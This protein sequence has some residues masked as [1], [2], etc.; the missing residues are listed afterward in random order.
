MKLS[1]PIPSGKNVL[2]MAAALFLVFLAACS[3][4]LIYSGIWQDKPVT[5]DGKATEWK[6]PLDYYD[7]KTKLNF[8]ITNDMSNIYFCIRATEDITQKGII[9]NGLQ[10]W[11]DTAGGKKGQVGMQFPVI[12]RTDKSSGTRHSEPQEPTSDETPVAYSLKSNYAGKNKQMKLTGFNGNINGLAEVPNIYGINACLNWDTNNIM[13][14]EA[15]IP[16]NSFYKSRLSL[17]DSSKVIG[18]SFVVTVST[19]GYG[20]GGGG[21]G[22][23]GGGGGGMG[24]GM[25][26]G[27]GGGGHGGHGGG[28]GSSES[29]ML[30]AHMKIRLATQHP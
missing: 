20:G 6:I 28:G 5:V 12:Q 9:R 18:I 7:D 19:P 1:Q 10:I 24:G 26:G 16:F 23:M 17:S 2:V 29:Q 11:I 3:S 4:P 22:G 21:G 13:I 15:S 27:G 14:Y 30:A 25:H 8:S